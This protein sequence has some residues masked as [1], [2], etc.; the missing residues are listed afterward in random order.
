[1]LDEKRLSLITE[2]QTA[3]DPRIGQVVATF[4]AI[5]RNDPRLVVIDGKTYP[6]QLGE[7]K[8]LLHFVAQMVDPIPDALYLACHCQHLGRFELS[9]NEFP[10]DNAGYKAWRAEASRRSAE[11]SANLMKEIGLDASM[12]ERVSKVVSK[13]GR[14]TNSEVQTM[15]DALCLTFL[16]L[17]AE[18]FVLRHTQEEMARILKRTWMKMSETGHRIALETP[19][20]AAVKKA[21]EIALSS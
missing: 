3:R 10:Q 4:E 18:D 21:V 9:R 17:D 5:G 12:I 2:L 13:Q 14:A 20:A 6:R 7:T 11:R 1:M 16:I 8:L 19:L 15:E